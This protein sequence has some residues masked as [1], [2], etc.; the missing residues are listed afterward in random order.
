MRNRPV[1]SED[2]WYAMYFVF[3]FALAVWAFA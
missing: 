2:F 3:M 1:T